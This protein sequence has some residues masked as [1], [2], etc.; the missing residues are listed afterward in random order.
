[1]TP[2]EFRTYGY[3][4][5]D[6]IAHFL[7][8]VQHFPVLPDV[9]PGSLVDALPAQAPETGEDFAQILEDFERE[10]VPRNTHWNHPRFLGY[11]ANS[12]TPPAILAELLASALNPNGMLWKSAPAATELEQVTLDWLRQ[13]LN[14]SPS[15]FGQI[16]D[17]A[18][19]ATFHAFVAARVRAGHDG[20]VPGLRLYASEHAHSSI[21]K[22]AYASGLSKSGFRSIPSDSNF[23]MD[24]A[25]LRAAIEAD[26][27]AGHKPFCVVASIGTTSVASVDP[28]EPIAAIANEFGLWLHVDAAYA[29]STAIDPRYQWIFK[30]IEQADSLVVNPHKW[31]FVPMDLSVFYCRNRE[32][33][34]DA[35]SLTPEYL[36]TEE[37]PRAIN[38]NEYGLPL[39]RRFRSLKL[40]FV[41]R[42][43]GRLK[44]AEMIHSQIE[45]TKR[46]AA[47]IEAHPDFEV[48]APVH[49]SLVVFRHTGGEAINNAILDRLNHSGVALVSPNVL[50]GKK[51]IRLAVGNFQTRWD[52]LAIVWQELQD[53][54]QEALTA[55]VPSEAP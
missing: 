2:E 52:D 34:R 12:S 5:I 31:L 40:W 51:V 39:G 42:S 15:W 50:L 32:W 54:A 38:Y 25:A 26:L 49:F 18:S 44:L 17:T 33:L 24:I 10:I 7:E 43:Y 41:M 6:W 8:H 13:W 48:C 30:G 14:L 20:A 9:Q 47:L 28:L 55:G 27:A 37:N 35:F 19:T 36:R 4:S 23:R 46:L 1:M 21:P 3:A 45:D 53:A 29:G 16:L 22:G 11:F